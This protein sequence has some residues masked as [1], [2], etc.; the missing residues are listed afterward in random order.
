MKTFLAIDNYHSPD[1]RDKCASWGREVFVMDY[2]R[3][4]LFHH[5]LCH[6]MKHPGLI[7]SGTRYFAWEWHG[8]EY[9]AVPLAA[10]I[11]LECMSGENRAALSLIHAPRF[12]KEVL[13]VLPRESWELTEIAV[14]DWL[15]LE[16]GVK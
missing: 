14:R 16:V 5:L 7:G 3:G 8:V 2:A 10:A 13:K 4:E 15:R 11:L 9:A 12:A 1:V 6:P